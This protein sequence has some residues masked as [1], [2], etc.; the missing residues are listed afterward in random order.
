MIINELAKR[1]QI[2]QGFGIHFMEF[3]NY[4]KDNGEVQ[5]QCQE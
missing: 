5:D 4:P 2:T 1:D 3:R